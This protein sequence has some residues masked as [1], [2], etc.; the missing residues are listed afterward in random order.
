MKKRQKLRMGIILFS[1]FWFPATFYYLSPVLILQTASQ[2]II[3]GSFIVFGL[4]FAAALLLGRAFC[5]WVCP[6]AGCQ[7][8]LFLARDR[9]VTR[10]DF[11]KWVIWAPWL[12]AIAFLVFRRGGYERVDFLYETTYGFS[13][14]D[15]PSLTAYFTVLF[16]LIVFPASAVGKRSFC[17]H[18]CWMAPFMILGRKVRNTVGWSSLRLSA[19]SEGCTHCHTCTDN[20]PMSL[21]VETMIKQGKMENAECIL[22]GS[23]VDGCEFDILKYSFN[24]GVE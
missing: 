15:V 1:F 9:K 4:Q 20:C 6:A 18:L 24:S 8:A 17:H 7:E 13:V 19:A 14:A 21:P 5:G 12:G 23:C 10:G 2:G 3:N 22:C 11:I 16:L